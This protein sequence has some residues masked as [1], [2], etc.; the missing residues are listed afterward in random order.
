MKGFVTLKDYW[1]KAP[2]SPTMQAEAQRRID[3]CK[4]EMAQ[5]RTPEEKAHISWKIM[6]YRGDARFGRNY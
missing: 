2:T 1:T 4:A 3:A 5:A 6:V